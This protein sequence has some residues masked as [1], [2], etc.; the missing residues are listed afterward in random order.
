[1]LNALSAHINPSTRNS[2]EIRAYLRR[3]AEDERD[4]LDLT[5]RRYLGDDPIK[6]K[7]PIFFEDFDRRLQAVIRELG[8]TPRQMAVFAER[9]HPRLLLVQMP[10]TTDS[11]DANSAPGSVSKQLGDLVAVLTDATKGLLGMSESGTTNFPWSAITTPPGAEIWLSRLGEPEVKWAGITDVKSATLEYAIW[12]FRF[13]WG[14]CSK[15]EKP[16]PYLQHE[17]DLKVER[18]GCR[19]R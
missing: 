12:T 1:V 16:D 11:I 14:G 19:T 15:T 13:D 6:T 3:V 4:V 9:M 8:G 10:R 5:K 18:A 2:K 7:A 17:V